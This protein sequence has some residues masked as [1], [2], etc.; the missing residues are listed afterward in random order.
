LSFFSLHSSIG[1]F[2]GLLLILV[3]LTGSLLVFEQDFDHFMI[4]QQYCHRTITEALSLQ[5]FSSNVNY[6]TPHSPSQS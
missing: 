2:I 1:F 6:T 5:R 4:S 3:G